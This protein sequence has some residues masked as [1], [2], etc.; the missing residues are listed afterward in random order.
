[1][2]H[3]LA[4]ARRAIT[5]FGSE[6]TIVRG[7]AIWVSPHRQEFRAV[8]HGEYAYSHDH[9]GRRTQPNSTARRTTPRLASGEIIS[10]ELLDFATGDGK[11]C[12]PLLTSH[13]LRQ[14]EGIGPNFDSTSDVTVRSGPERALDS[15]ADSAVLIRA[16]IGHGHSGLE[17]SEPS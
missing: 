16:S 4:A 14:L 17:L 8:K 5:A 6:T 13:Q 12:R 11:E 7:A 15:A 9:R 1:V 2:R 10:E 3:S